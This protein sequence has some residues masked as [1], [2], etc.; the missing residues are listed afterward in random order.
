LE[1]RLPISSLLKASV[2]RAFVLIPMFTEYQTDWASFRQKILMRLKNHCGR[3]F[4]GN[5]GSYTIPCSLPSGSGSANPYLPIAAAARYREYAR[6]L[7]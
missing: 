5:T 3:C 6:S 2:N 4:P 7:E 1:E